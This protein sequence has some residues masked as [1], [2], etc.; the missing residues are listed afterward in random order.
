V[1]AT[2]RL[3]DRPLL[4]VV[5]AEDQAIP[6]SMPRRLKELAG[7]AELLIIPGA[8]HVNVAQA[9]EAYARPLIDFYERSLLRDA[10]P[11]AERGD[12]M[13]RTGSR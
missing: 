6:P 5:G 12:G 11:L 2:R 4:I 8:G 9:G 13:A 10:Q 1:D 3:G 7:N